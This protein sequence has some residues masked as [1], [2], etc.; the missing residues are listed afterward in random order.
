MGRVKCTYT[1]PNGETVELFFIGRL[2]T[3]LGRDANTIRKWEIAGILPSTCFR[4]RLGDRL[5]TAEQIEAVVKV[6]EK[7][8][9]MQ[10]R[11]MCDTSFTKRV[12]EE[13][14]RLE[15]KYKGGKLNE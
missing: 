4:D 12:T 11:R 5:Y 15:E 10:G 1:L 13:F 9:L 7:C 14:K 6:A 8:K 2:A 3:A